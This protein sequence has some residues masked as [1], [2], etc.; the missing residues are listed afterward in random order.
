METPLPVF[1]N[2]VDLGQGRMPGICL[3]EL[4]GAVAPDRADIAN[5]LQID[6]NSPPFEAL[7]RRFRGWYARTLDL[8]GTYYLEAVERLFKRN[9]LAA[10]RFVALGETVDLARVRCPMYLIAASEDEVV[11]PSQLLATERLAGTPPHRIR[12]EVLAT[13][14][15][16][17]FMGRDVVAGAWGRVAR[18]LA[19]R[20]A[21][22]PRAPARRAVRAPARDH[23]GVARA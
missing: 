11:A 21:P 2:M 23:V 13:G 3:L 5:T 20:R 4:W 22:R 12:R 6:V 1:Q 15:L 7:E 8:P 18:W 9:E 14:H 10:G 17:L 19:E 16:G